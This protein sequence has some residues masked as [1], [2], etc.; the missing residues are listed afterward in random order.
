MRG[1]M[2]GLDERPS[3]FER[4]PLEEVLFVR[5]FVAPCG[6]DESPI[7]GPG[8]TPALRTP[9][10]RR[11]EGGVRG[12]GYVR[13]KLQRPNPL[14]LARFARSTSPPQGEVKKAIPFSR[15]DR[16]RVSLSTLSNSDAI[17]RHRRA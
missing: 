6:H 16:A 5:R 9:S 13:E 14:T 1:A 15:R 17:P 7:M 8:A 3:L 4:A 12:V 10:P 2:R 11:G